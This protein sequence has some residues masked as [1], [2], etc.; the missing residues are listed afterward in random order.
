MRKTVIFPLLIL[1]LLLSSCVSQAAALSTTADVPQTTH[2]PVATPTGSETSP[3]DRAQP[4]IT[5]TVDPQ[6]VV[7]NP[8]EEPLQGSAGLPEGNNQGALIHILGNLS[9]TGLFPDQPITL[10][11]GIFYYSEGGVGNP[12][13]RLVDRL[14]VLSDLNEDGVQDAVLMLEH[15]SDGSGR[16]TYLVAVLGVWAAPM[17]V[18]AIMIGDRIGVKSLAVEGSQVTADIVAQGPG[19]AD[20][21]ASWNSRA[22]YSLEGGKLVE[23]N[24]NELNRISLDDLN[25]TEWSLIDLHSGEEADSPG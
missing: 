18:E 22:T 7:T 3:A 23:T 25:G 4:A 16:F 2:A 21:C 17:P 10:S 20:C 14:I 9:Y 24:R 8:V 1:G 12:R 11:D 6:A 5:A 15:D 19:D 13:V